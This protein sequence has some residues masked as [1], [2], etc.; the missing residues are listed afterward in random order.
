MPPGT[1]V[2][3]NGVSSSGKTSILKAL[4]GILEEPYLDAGLDKFLVFRH[5]KALQEVRNKY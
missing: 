5:L 2:L 3:L 1:I 4:Q